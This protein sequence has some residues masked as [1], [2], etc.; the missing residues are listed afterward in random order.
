[1]MK[2]QNFFDVTKYV[3]PNKIWRLRQILVAFSYYMNFN[4][5]FHRSNCSTS[6]VSVR[7]NELQNSGT[8]FS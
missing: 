4:L 1:M 5:K 2:F 3:I 7:K 8:L 6:K